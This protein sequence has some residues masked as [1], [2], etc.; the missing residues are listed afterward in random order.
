ME[1][2]KLINYSTNMCQSGQG[3]TTVYVQHF[4]QLHNPK[5]P[6]ANNIAHVNAICIS[7]FYVMWTSVFFFFFFE[8]C[9]VGGFT[10]I[11]KKI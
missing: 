10:T 3:T 11:Q 4:D 1:S 5:Y 2:S 8:I 9:E 7:E 6:M